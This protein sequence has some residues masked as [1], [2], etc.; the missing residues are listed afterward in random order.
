MTYTI[1]GRAIPKQYLSMGVLGS[2]AATAVYSRSGKA[3]APKNAE[4]AKRAVPI[5]AGS[6]EEEEFIRKF[7]ADAEKESTGAASK[8]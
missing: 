7:I 1:L 4:E 3:A 2:I 6:S 8:H 5:N